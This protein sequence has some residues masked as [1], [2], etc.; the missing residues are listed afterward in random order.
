MT[1]PGAEVKPLSH[2]SLAMGEAPVGPAG[3]LGADV[4]A[5]LPPPKHTAAADLAAWS[6]PRLL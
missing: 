2:A 4:A 3:S 5:A 1:P 6:S